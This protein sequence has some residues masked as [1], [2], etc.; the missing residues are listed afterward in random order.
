MRAERWA[1]TQRCQLEKAWN[2]TFLEHFLSLCIDPLYF[3]KFLL[4]HSGRPGETSLQI[5]SIMFEENSK[6]FCSIRCRVAFSI[7]DFYFI[8]SVWRNVTLPL[9]WFK[10][11][12]RNSND[13][14]WLFLQISV[15]QTIVNASHL[16]LLFQIFLNYIGSSELTPYLKKKSWWI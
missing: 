11:P 14:V 16:Q 15:I 9:H 5:M 6:A 1:S 2:C 8:W 13:G 3:K 7:S 4:N 10:G 12:L